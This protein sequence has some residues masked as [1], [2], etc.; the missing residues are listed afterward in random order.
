MYRYL[1]EY[2]QYVIWPSGRSITR[3]RVEVGVAGLRYLGLEL[4][5]RWNPRSLREVEPL[6]A[7][8][9]SLL[10]PNVGD[11]NCGAPPL[12]VGDLVLRTVRG[13]RIVQRPDLQVRGGVAT[14]AAYDRD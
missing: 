2:I 6:A 13:T 4:G 7:G 1:T 8:S 5:G 14:S 12:C 9:L 10:L 11:R 3:L